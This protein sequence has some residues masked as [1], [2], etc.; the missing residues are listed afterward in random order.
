MNCPICQHELTRTDY[1]NKIFK[2]YN[3]YCS[4]CNSYHI[5]EEINAADYYAN[6]YHKG[7][8]YN[9]Y[10]STLINKLSLVSNRIAGRFYF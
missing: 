9:N 5:T 10:L 4:N 8:S 2:T 3:Y 1:Y 7:F 6:E